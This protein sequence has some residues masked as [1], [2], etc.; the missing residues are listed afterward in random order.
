MIYDGILWLV[1][2][3]RGYSSRMQLDPG[4]RSMQ[5]APRSML[6]V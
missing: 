5:R 2:Q 1:D 4:N 3:R 6:G